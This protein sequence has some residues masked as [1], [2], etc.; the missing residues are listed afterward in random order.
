MSESEVLDKVE[1]YVDLHQPPTFRL[2]VVRG[3]VSHDGDWWY[4][5]VKPTPEDV[6][7]RD[8]RDVMED[9]ED[10]L[11]AKEHLKVLLLPTLRGD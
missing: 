11:K 9:I 10:E 8:Y 4:V 7:A 1:A 5:V 6:R 3:D 2:N